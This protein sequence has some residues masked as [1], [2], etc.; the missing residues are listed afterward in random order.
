M[1]KWCTRVWR[2]HGQTDILRAT[3]RLTTRCV[4]KTCTRQNITTRQGLPFISLLLL[5]TNKRALF[6]ED[7]RDGAWPAPRSSVEVLTS[8]WPNW[9]VG[10]A[11]QSTAVLYTQIAAQKHQSNIGLLPYCVINYGKIV[12]QRQ[13]LPWESPPAV[14]ITR[15]YNLHWRWRIE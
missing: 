14:G 4:G 1:H 9:T 12:G 10:N 2:T 6:S 5:Q 15:E 7:G 3:P 13:K 11:W 8:K